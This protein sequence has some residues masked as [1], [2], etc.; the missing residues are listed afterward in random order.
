MLARWSWPQV[1]VTVSLLTETSFP[2]SVYVLSLATWNDTSLALF[3]DYLAIISL[4]IFVIYFHLT[5]YQHL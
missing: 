5:Y 2:F 1:M 4:P 3:D